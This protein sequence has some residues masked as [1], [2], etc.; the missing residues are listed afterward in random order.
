MTVY[1]IAHTESSINLGGQELSILDQVQWLLE[2]GHDSWLLARERSAIYQ[3]A[4]KRGLP[5]CDVPFQGSMNPK[6]II[7]LL[8]FIRRKK[9]DLIDCHSSRDASASMVAKLLGTP[10]VRTHHIG[11]TVKDSVFHR[12]VWKYGN[13]RIVAICANTA[14]QI[15]SRGLADHHAINMIP[16][17]IDLDRFRPDIDGTEIRRLFGIP[18]TAPVITVVGM[19]RPDK[20]QRYLV[21]AVDRIIEKAPDAWFLIVGSPTRAE[22]LAELK[23]EIQQTKHQERIILTGFQSA[24]EKFIAASD[25]IVVT[26]EVEGR[27][28]AAYQA[29]AMKR[30]VV[31]S[32][33]GG[34]PEFVRHGQTG[35]LYPHGDVKELARLIIH[36]L[37]SDVSM[38]IENAYAFAKAEIGFESMMDSTLK[39]YRNILDS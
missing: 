16:P 33:V 2:H 17:G 8:R 38:Q 6:A 13:N 28:L 20:A 32:A 25:I 23:V 5:V 7:S 31:A 36:V 19:I 15:A 1:R 4:M 12:L 9:I 11:G 3:E 14:E 22:Y 34:T 35:F 29:F 10:V 39:I 18:E 26:S 30:V 27:S 21:Q 37:E 24:V